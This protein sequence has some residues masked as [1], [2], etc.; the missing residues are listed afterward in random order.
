MRLDLGGTGLTPRSF[1][2]DEGR[3]GEVSMT[4][5]EVRLSHAAGKGRYRLAFAPGEPSGRSLTLRV[6][7]GEPLELS[8]AREG[9]R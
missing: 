3:A 4:A 6:G 5:G 1:S 8:L 9:T 7:D 2:Q